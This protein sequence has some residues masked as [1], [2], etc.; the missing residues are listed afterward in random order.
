MLLKSTD[1]M[2]F[3]VTNNGNQFSSLFSGRSLNNVLTRTLADDQLDIL[4]VYRK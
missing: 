2:F 4:A 1:N 3:S